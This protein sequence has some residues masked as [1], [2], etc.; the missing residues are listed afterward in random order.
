[1]KMGAIITCE[2]CKKVH[3][4]SSSEIENI[5]TMWHLI[6]TVKCPYCGN[7]ITWDDGVLDLF[8]KMPAPKDK[9]AYERAKSSDI[10]EYWIQKYVEENYTKLGFSK[11]EGPFEAGPDFKGIYKG[12]EVIVE[13]ERD[14][15]SYISHKHHKDE[16]FKKVS[17]L[18]VLNPSE[19]PKEIKNKLPETIIHIDVDDFVKWWRPKAKAYAK[20]K[21]IQNIIDLVAGEFQK[22]FVRDCDDKNRDMSTCPECDLCPYFGEGTTYEASSVFQEMALKFIALYKYSIPSEDFKLADIHPS[23]IDKFYSDY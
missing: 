21:R 2:E 14:C 18:I 13:V 15:R 16:R 5:G 22:K 6:W 20:E 23:E 7:Q 8:D 19:P 12:K 3:R 1:M 9:N 17:I 4:H 10:R 11:I